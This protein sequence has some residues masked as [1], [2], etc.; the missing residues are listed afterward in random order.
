MKQID[1]YWKALDAIGLEHLQLSLAASSQQA[2]GLVLSHEDGQAL[3]IH[4]RVT[5]DERWNT[6]QVQVSPVGAAGNQ[7][8][9]TSDGQ[10]I[11]RD[12][13]DQILEQ[14]SGCLDIDIQATPFTN[15][16]AIK[17]LQLEP[18]A[19][20]EIDVAYVTIPQFA[21]R[22]DSQRYT[23]LARAVDQ[24]RYLF[25]SLETEFKAELKVDELDLVTDYQGLWRRLD[26]SSR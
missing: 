20:A 10:G 25:E 11:W 6:R 9:L 5:A 12:Q 1:V 18:G 7:I 4:Y 2:D 21:L 8:Q 26:P 19:S 17:R 16:L 22:R 15:T 14:L 13:H 23:C 3:R 24:S